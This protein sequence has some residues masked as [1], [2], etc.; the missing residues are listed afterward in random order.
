MGIISETPQ[1]SPC[2]ISLIY[3]ISFKSYIII[4]REN[5][6]KPTSLV[7]NF[8]ISRKE[9]SWT[10]Q[11]LKLIF[12][13]SFSFHQA[14]RIPIFESDINLNPRIQYT[15]YGWHLLGIISEIPQLT[16]CEISMR[17]LFPSKVT[18][19]FVEKRTDFLFLKNSKVWLKNRF[20]KNALQRCRRPIFVIWL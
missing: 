12:I 17:Y 5:G 13:K 8:S 14:R 10:V 19:L 15:C 6:F 1:L 18:E 9:I 16:P 4:F 2:E 11:I 7:S 3:K 20:K